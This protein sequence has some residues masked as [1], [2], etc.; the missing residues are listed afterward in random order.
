MGHKRFYNEIK[1]LSNLPTVMTLICKDK[2]IL[3]EKKT[4]IGK[5]ATI[6]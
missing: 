2:D 6:L 5:M 3:S 4:N 1:N